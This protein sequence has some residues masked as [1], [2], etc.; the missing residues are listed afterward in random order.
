[1]TPSGVVIVPTPETLELEAQSRARLYSAL[2][3]SPLFCYW[4]S[5][6][7]SKSVYSSTW[8]DVK[9]THTHTHTHTHIHTRLG[10]MCFKTYLFCTAYFNYPLFPILLSLFSFLLE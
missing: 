3:I 7:T 5:Q 10:L 1:M 9:H 4:S 8:I 2:T 6:C